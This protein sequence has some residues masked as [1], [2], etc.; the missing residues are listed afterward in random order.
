MVNAIRAQ[1]GNVDFIAYDDL[2]HNC[3]DRAV[4]KSDL[5]NWLANAKK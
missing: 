2:S 1:G 3:W 5:I 4:E